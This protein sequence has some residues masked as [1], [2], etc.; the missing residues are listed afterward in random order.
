CR[1][2]DWHG[3]RGL[4]DLFDELHVTP[5]GGRELAGVV[6]A[7]AGPVKA[8]GREQVPLLTRDLARLTADAHGGVGEETGSGARLRRRDRAERVDETARKVRERTGRWLGVLGK[9]CDRNFPTR[10]AR[11]SPGAARPRACRGSGP[12]RRDGTRRPPTRVDAHP[13][14]GPHAAG[15]RRTWRCGCPHWGRGRGERGG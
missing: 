1:A 6:V 9:L 5:R 7:V 8:I 4:A 12:A 3:G 11:T 13:R 2:G 10:H 14:D 15:R